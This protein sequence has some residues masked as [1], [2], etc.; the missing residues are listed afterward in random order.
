MGGRTIP[1]IIVAIDSLASSEAF[2]TPVAEHPDFLQIVTS[3]E[4]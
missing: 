4:Q 1:T 3:F 2:A